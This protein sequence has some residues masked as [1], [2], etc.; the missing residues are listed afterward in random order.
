MTHFA[1][2]VGPPA[3]LA[4]LLGNNG[5]PGALSPTSLTPPT[6]IPPIL[7]IDPWLLLRDDGTPPIG[8]PTPIPIPAATPPRPADAKYAD[9]PFPTTPPDAT[10]RI[11]YNELP[12]FER[13]TPTNPPAPVNDDER[14]LDAECE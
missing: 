14:E 1:F 13:C 9:T 7:P 11:L 12:E 4:K 2:S 10:F 8:I 3:N 5:F 6:L